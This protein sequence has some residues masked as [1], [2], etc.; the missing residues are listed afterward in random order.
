MVSGPPV[1]G[2]G[3]LPRDVSAR[4]PRP[5]LLHAPPLHALRREPPA[6]HRDRDAW[7]LCGRDGNLLLLPDRAA[8]GQHTEGSIHSLHQPGRLQHGSVGVSIRLRYACRS[9]GSSEPA[10]HGAGRPSYDGT[11][12]QTELDSASRSAQLASALL[13]PDRRPGERLDTAQVEGAGRQRPAEPIQSLTPQCVHGVHLRWLPSPDASPGGSDSPV[14]LWAIHPRRP[15]CHR[16][17]QRS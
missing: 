9:D 4:Y 8:D 1:R 5:G 14:C 16:P 15:R 11:Q 6:R 12:P 13:Q 7:A 10:E 3:L 2:A 17:L